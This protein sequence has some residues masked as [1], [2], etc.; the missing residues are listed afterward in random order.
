VY[1]LENDA[2]LK[3]NLSVQSGN[4]PHPNPTYSKRQSLCKSSPTPKFST[5]TCTPT[6]YSPETNRLYNRKPPLTIPTSHIPINRSTKRRKP[7]R[8]K[9]NRLWPTMSRQYRTSNGPRSDA[10]REVVL[11][12]Q[13]L[14]A[15]LRH[16]IHGADLA[17]VLGGRVRRGNHVFEADAQLL[18][19][20]EV[21]EGF[22][23]GLR[24]GGGGEGGVVAHL[25]CGDLL[26]RS[27][28]EWM[29]YFGRRTEDM[30]IPKS[31]PMAKPMPPERTILK[32]QL[33][34]TPFHYEELL[35]RVI[36]RR[37]GI[38]TYC[39]ACC[40]WPACGIDMP[41]GPPDG[42]VGKKLMMA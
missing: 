42:R 16:R 7:D 23:A 9:R 21:G 25:F 15:A 13:A 24:D 34:E 37:V 33:S 31:P 14:D 30:N 22:A 27:R 20:G 10:V 26:M 29:R 3:A 40:S 18:A 8:P 19:H 1:V 6:T 4:D 35:V 38:H 12:P 36:M 32:G 28:M 41:E 11:P 2:R 17:E 39:I 5:H